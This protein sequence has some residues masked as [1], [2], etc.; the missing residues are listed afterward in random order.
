MAKTVALFFAPTL[1]LSK[2]KSLNERR[3]NNATGLP[4]DEKRV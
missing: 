2:I 1:L 4:L 3:Y